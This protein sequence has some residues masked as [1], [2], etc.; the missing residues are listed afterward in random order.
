MPGVV[1]RSA[2]LNALQ[3]NTRNIICLSIFLQRTI[4]DPWIGQHL[5][6]AK[7]GAENY[8]IGF[9]V[10]APIITWTL[11]GSADG[12]NLMLISLG[13]IHH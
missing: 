1:V 7:W 3:M 5:P 2:G 9:W 10:P 12:S 4:S 6:D 8:F 11:V 13:E